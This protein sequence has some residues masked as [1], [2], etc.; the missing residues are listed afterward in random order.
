MITLNHIMVIDDDEVSTLL[1]TR[2]LDSIYASHS[3]T[4]FNLVD[5]AIEF[6]CSNKHDRNFLPDLILLDIN[7]PGK[8]GWDFMDIY[9]K[10][11]AEFFP[12]VVIV[13][14]SNSKADQS[15]AALYPDYILGYIV[16]PVERLDVINIITKVNDYLKV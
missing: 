9:T 16:K 12:P 6:L 2:V 15:K 7:M 1:T 4:T 5:N 3:I 8:T 11:M 10:Q 14:S 13:S